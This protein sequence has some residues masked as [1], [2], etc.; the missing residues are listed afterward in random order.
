MDALNGATLS[1]DGN[2]IV[3]YFTGGSFI[4]GTLSQRNALCAHC[5]WAMLPPILSE[6]P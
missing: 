5:I 6:R 3:L 2:D 4:L 1:N